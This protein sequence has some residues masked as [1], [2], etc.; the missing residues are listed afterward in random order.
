MHTRYNRLMT[1]TFKQMSLEELHA[2]VS[3][4]GLPSFRFAQLASWAYQK[5]VS[6]YDEMT[7]LSK[8]MRQDLAAELPLSLPIVANRQISRDGTRKYVLRFDDDALAETV[9]IPSSDGRLTICCSSQA[10]CAMGCTF[11]ATGKGGLA[12]SLYP[13]EIADQITIAG[14]DMGMRV[15]NVVVMGQGE[16]F[17]NY[18]NTLAALRI[19][20]D[21]KLLNIGARHITVSTCGILPGIERFGHEPE[22]FTLAVSLHSAV[23][24]TRDALMPGVKG[25]PLDKLRSSLVRYSDSSGRRF[26]LEYALI[27][28]I[29]DDAEHL[30]ALTRFC[31]GLL[32]HVN[33][34]PLNKVE[35][36][37][38]LPSSRST[39]AHW[40][41]ELEAKGIAVTVRRS[42]GSDIAG[43]CGQLANAEK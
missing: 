30:E 31:R 18:D 26:S 42:A 8:A 20:N 22:Q 5:G 34:I 37:P 6:S 19:M 27:A 41:S 29:N 14:R 36:S 13:G 4:R 28:D 35:G 38:F 24:K 12:R 43:A 15:S 33:L 3:E 21:T 17:A 2:F 7:N 1:K 16:P 23:Q 25:A 11:C 32:C 10:G 39:I 40:Q 9:A